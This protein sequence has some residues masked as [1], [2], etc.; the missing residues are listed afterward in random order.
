MDDPDINEMAAA[1]VELAHVEDFFLGAAR[2]RPSVR[3]LDVA[4]RTERLEPRVMQ[5]LVALAEA[6]GGVVT[7][8][9]LITRCW[10]GVVVGDDA[11]NRVM[12]K[13][14]RLSQLDEGESFALDTIPRVG[15][16]LLAD[17]QPV[18]A[19]D[20]PAP[21]P[22]PLAFAFAR[23]R[24]LPIAAGAAAI[25]AA[26]WI[27]VGSAERQERYDIQSIELVAQSRRAEAYPA[28]SPD[29]Q[30]IVYTVS[31]GET[32]GSST[33]LF[34]RS[35]SGGEEL[36]LTDSPEYEV[37]PAFSPDGGRL[38]F[39]RVPY[40]EDDDALEPCRIMV[41]VFPSGLE[42]QVGVC[43]A[44]TWVSRI[45]W[46]A[47]GR[48]LIYNDA[49]IGPAGRGPDELRIL[50]IDSSVV[51]PLVPPALT[52]Y[53][54]FNANVSPDG[55]RLAFVR[56]A[57]PAAA[58]AYVYDLESGRLTQ[59]TRDEPV[60]HVAWAP[61]SRRLFVVI[62][63]PMSTDLSLHHADG[64]GEIRR[65]PLGPNL[66]YRPYSASGLLAFEL[67]SR[68]ENL[69]RA[70]RTAAAEVT[71][72]SQIDY[73]A[74]Y[75]HEGVLAFLSLQSEIWLY[76]QEPGR[77]PR[78]L[79]ALT[80]LAPRGPRW[81]PDGR[82]I[83]FAGTRGG[84]ARLFIIDAG[85][86]LVREVSI[87]S[88][89]ELGNPSWS[90]DGRSLLFTSTGPEGVRIE[91]ARLEDHA[92]P[93]PIS[94]YGWV[95]AVETGEG[96]FARALG[97]PGVWRLT[98]GGEPEQ[99]FP[100]LAPPSSSESG[101]MSAREWAVAGGRIYGL[102]TSDPEQRRVVARPIEGGPAVDISPVGSDFAGSLT[103][104]PRTGEIV[105]AT[106]VEDQVDVA[107]MRLT[108]GP[109]QAVGRAA[110]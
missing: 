59:V 53:G 21:A 17:P 20:P 48:S 84:R 98:D 93:E 56:H 58:D 96:V 37:A 3:E 87:D 8:D 29:G 104:D 4:G 36:Q 11:I 5:A 14:R 92:V 83:V 60:M 103:V 86:G 100:E 62:D 107:L 23:R 47:D 63:G 13:I 73:G 69:V 89:D 82:E 101:R 57:A 9:E 52:G 110:P 41:R 106:L 108:G 79:A 91:R 99:M 39:V 6:E 54:D 43:E 38:A 49:K 42:R 74:D 25:V 40:G 61:D 51:R 26:G 46:T 72:G 75:S 16:R 76:L 66:L 7:R 105:Y 24:W 22:V 78:R 33:D 64:S 34:M 45:T 15:Y 18:A 67:H 55:R 44:S 80:D 35:L 90:H 70:G 12:H 81:S 2:V 19:A 71:N 65:Y 10:A 77:A 109:G 97:R 94:G 68:I 88:D 85:S 31:T 50:D 1:R 95:E 28:L 102:D 32:Q 27:A 30:F